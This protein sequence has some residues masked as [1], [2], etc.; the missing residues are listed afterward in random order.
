[1][2]NINIQGATVNMFILHDSLLLLL[3]K[4]RGHLKIRNQRFLENGSKL[5]GL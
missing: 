3:K 2:I 1:V 5:V 4:S